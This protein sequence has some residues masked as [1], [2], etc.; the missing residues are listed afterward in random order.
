MLSL[1]LL[2]LVPSDGLVLG[3][4]AGRA[5]CSTARAGVPRLGLFD[6]F[7]KKQS[8][9][10]LAEDLIGSVA[11][12]AELSSDELTA[13]KMA[14]ISTVAPAAGEVRYTLNEDAPETLIMPEH[15]YLP[16]SYFQMFRGTIL[17]EPPIEVRTSQRPCVPLDAR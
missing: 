13:L 14:S 6:G 2:A 7:F 1:L 11:N 17:K 15:P 12:P 9:E 3:P 4:L 10:E 8:P 16:M 5:A